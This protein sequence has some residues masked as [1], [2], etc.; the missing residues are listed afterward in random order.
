[1]TEKMTVSMFSMIH[2]EDDPLV[3][4]ETFEAET[5]EELMDKFVDL[6]RSVADGIEELRAA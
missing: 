5:K 1:M 4:A 6:L 3:A 2:G